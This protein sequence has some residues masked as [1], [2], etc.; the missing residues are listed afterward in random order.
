MSFCPA[1]FC[2][3]LPSS[4][5]FSKMAVESKTGRGMP[6]HVLILDYQLHD[7]ICENIN[8]KRIFLFIHIQRKLKILD[9]DKL[10]TKP[11]TFHQKITLCVFDPIFCT[12]SSRYT[13]NIVLKENYR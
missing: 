1:S 13:T 12:A 3:I 2:A 4:I 11:K 8:F 7:I 5:Q 10:L 9:L 6:L